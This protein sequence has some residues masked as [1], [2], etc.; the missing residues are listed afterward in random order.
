VSAVTRVRDARV[1]LLGA[2][3]ASAL[4]SAILAFGTVMLVVALADFFQ[5]LPLGLRRAAI[6]LGVLLAFV[7]GSRKLWRGR[8]AS[9]LPSVALFLEELLPELQFALVT[10]VVPAGRQDPA[11]LERAVEQGYSAGALQPPILRALVRPAVGLLALL[12]AL[13][14][15]P[16]G[17]VTRV[18]RPRPGDLLLAPRGRGSPLDRLNHLV[19]VVSPPAYAERSPETLDDPA[20][21]RALE[22]SAIVVRGRGAA[23]APAES[24][25]LVRG[26]VVAPV[27]VAGDTWSLSVTMPG[28][29]EVVRLVDRGRN[30]LLT[31]EPVLD[32]PPT[33]TLRSPR[34]DTTL[35]RPTGSLLL[36]A[37]ASDDIGLGVFWIELLLTTGGGERFTTTT[38]R[39]GQVSPGGAVGTAIRLA[40][41]LDTMELGPGDVLN[42]RAVARDRNDVTGPGEGSSDTRT[43]RIADPE[44]KDA[45]P[46]VPASAA[47]LDTTVLSQRMLIIRAET[48][49]VRQ[50]RF[51]PDSFRMQSQRLGERQR[52][53][54]DRVQ[55]LILELET[56]TDVGFIEETEESKLLRVAGLAMRRAEDHLMR[57]RVSAALPE[58]YQ[59]LDALDK[60]RTSRRLYLRGMLPRIVVDL[61]QVRLTGTEKAQVGPR[62]PR[63][64][65]PDPRGRMLE[66]LE[67]L[68]PRSGRLGPGLA[69][70][71]TMIRAAAL[72]DTP[73]AAPFLARAIEA[74]RAGRDPRL[75]LRQSRRVLERGS[76]SEPSLSAWRGGR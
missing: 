24:L 27:R 38:R 75:W 51:T 41:R 6:P 58:M 1:A 16:G 49:L 30:R 2:L 60:G 9:S 66:R 67:R 8:R 69:D 71:L 17:S 52:M 56:A 13:V 18:L 76:E 70:S 72:T 21:V 46:I 12:L 68:L 42:L 33:V 61:E 10:A 74:L 73:E 25:G 34:S 28:R 19:V 48:L 11:L 7:A 63:L 35:A 53:L 31:L 62:S 65:L 20:S 39:L 43:I 55:A 23:V 14:A 3:A 64:P 47:T 44:L 22:G 29:A 57:A 37:T 32:A 59:A 4:L 36:D 40:L 15:L 54:Y 5:P 45:I 50:R 26:G